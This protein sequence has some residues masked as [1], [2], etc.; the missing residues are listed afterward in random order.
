M[1]NINSND[2]TMT[3]RNGY[4]VGR[5]VSVTDQGD[6]VGINGTMHRRDELTISE[7]GKAIVVN[8]SQCELTR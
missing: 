6:I 3:D 7:D 8:A 1:S 4:V 5:S 2:Y